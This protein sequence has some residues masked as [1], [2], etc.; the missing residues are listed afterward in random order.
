MAEDHMA[1]S[2]QKGQMGKLLSLNKS[3]A[4]ELK[5]TVVL[6]ALNLRLSELSVNIVVCF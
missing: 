2:L 5:S 4:L 3:F 1:I 6:Q